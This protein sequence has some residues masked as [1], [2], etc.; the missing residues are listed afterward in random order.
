MSSMAKAKKRMVVVTTD[1]SRKGVF[2]GEFVSQKNDVVVLAH[3]RM[4]VYWSAN[5]RGVVGLAAIGPQRGSRI[6]PAAPRIEINGVTAVMDCTPEAV[7]QWEKGLW[8]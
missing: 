5:T 7:Q 4:A 8:T 1:V 6:T 3:F 2:F